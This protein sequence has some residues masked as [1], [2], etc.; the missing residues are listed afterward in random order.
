MEQL[1]VKRTRNR[2]G[3]GRGVT[4]Y[5]P[6]N[7]VRSFELL[8]ELDKHDQAAL[9]RVEAFAANELERALNRVG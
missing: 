4:N 2:I 9:A 7:V 5:I 1:K 3:T 6:F 8:R